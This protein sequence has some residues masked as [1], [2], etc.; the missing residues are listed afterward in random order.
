MEERG[1]T[2]T[3]ISEL[4]ECVRQV[5]DYVKK[6]ITYRLVGAIKFIGNPRFFIL[7]FSGW[8][9]FFVVL[10]IFMVKYMIQVFL[11]NYQ[12]E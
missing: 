12:V 5:A 4:A 3:I 9:F 2:T 7:K 11:P 6:T 8:G 10:F 1:Y